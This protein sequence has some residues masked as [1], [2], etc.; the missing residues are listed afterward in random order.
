M[1]R[2]ILRKIGTISCKKISAKNK[3]FF[4]A[5][6]NAKVQIWD[7]LQFNYMVQINAQIQN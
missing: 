6:N 1:E 7:H 3:C 2:I 4:V 5:K